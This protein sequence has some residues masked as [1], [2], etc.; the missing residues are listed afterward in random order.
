[1]FERLSGALIEAEPEPEA[2]TVRSVK[3]N[4]MADQVSKDRFTA[5]PFTEMRDMS[6]RGKA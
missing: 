4:A 5:L 1:M 3:G 6:R 2:E